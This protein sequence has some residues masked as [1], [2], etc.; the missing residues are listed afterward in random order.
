MSSLLLLFL[1][2]KN[3]IFRFKSEL[4]FSQHGCTESKPTTTNFIVYPTIVTK[5]F[6]FN[7]IFLS[8]VL[9]LVGYF[10]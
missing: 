6:V 3:M 7:D 8:S 4:K 10:K 5:N 9:I 1:A 2:K